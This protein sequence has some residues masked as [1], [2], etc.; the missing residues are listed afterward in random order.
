MSDTEDKSVPGRE[1]YG[2]GTRLKSRPS[3][4]LVEFF[5]RLYLGDF[6]DVVFEDSIW[7]NVA[8]VV[9][10]VDC[11]IIPV[12]DAEKIVRLFLELDEHGPAVVDFDP[13]VGDS[14][15]N[16]EAYATRRLGDRVAGTLHTGR[17]RGDYY[18]TLSRMKCRRALMRVMGGILELRQA[19]LVLAADHVNTIMPGYTHLQHAQP[20]TLAH[21]LL[22]TIDSLSRDFERAQAAFRHGNVSPLGLGI[23][24]GSSFPLNRERTAAALGFDKLLPNGRDCGNR[25]YLLESANSAAIL[26]IN[27]HR[28]ATDLYEW[29]TSEFGMVR[30]HDS[31][32]MTS[33]MMP[34]KANPVLF[35]DLRARTGSVIGQLTSAFVMLKGSPANNIEASSADRPGLSA[36]NETAHALENLS[37]VL[38]RLGFDTGRMEDLVSKHW[39]TATDLA[40]ELV[41]STEL[42]FRQ[43]HRVVGS[44]VSRSIETY[45]SPADIGPGELVEAASSVLEDAPDLS[46]I[47]VR[48]ALDAWSSVQNRGSVGGPSPQLVSEHLA[49]ARSSYDRDLEWLEHEDRALKTARSDLFTSARTMVDEGDRT[50]AE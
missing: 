14:L 48:R 47:D 8:H 13:S 46:G 15:P 39:C 16:I 50:G 32:A 2:V 27:A 42:S 5:D 25:D 20:I 34:Q 44:L 12:D 29:S 3:R 24:S 43:A 28:L 17:S 10:L 11:N 9:M 45:K 33:S 26:M 1:T 22:G 31:D 38:P 4:E 21:Y 23:I 37:K 40:D 36:M 49:A 18:A 19:L 7:I 6:D 35:E 30:V 41:R